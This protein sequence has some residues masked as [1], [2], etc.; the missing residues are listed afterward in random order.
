MVGNRARQASRL[1]PQKRLHAIREVVKQM[2]SAGKAALPAF[3]P[4]HRH[5]LHRLV[6]VY[7]LLGVPD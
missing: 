4:H 5:E 1:Q 7:R 2:L 6:P 3:G